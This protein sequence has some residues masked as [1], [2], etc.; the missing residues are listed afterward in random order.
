MKTRSDAEKVLLQNYVSDE[1]PFYLQLWVYE[2]HSD[3]DAIICQFIY[4]CEKL[5]KCSNYLFILEY[6]ISLF[7]NCDYFSPK[8][9]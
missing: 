2:V 8:N 5:W 7:C 4:N 6:K 1:I 3:L 9:Q